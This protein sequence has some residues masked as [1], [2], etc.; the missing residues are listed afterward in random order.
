MW[1]TDFQKGLKILETLKEAVVSEEDECSNCCR[2]ISEDYCI[3][4]NRDLKY[5][6]RRCDECIE[7]F[8]DKNVVR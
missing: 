2:F 4:F 6:C 7:I 1:L 5:N 3:L 8:G